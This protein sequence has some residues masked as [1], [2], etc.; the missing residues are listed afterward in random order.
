MKLRTIGGHA[1]TLAVGGLVAVV[2][3][4]LVF[5]QPLV[6]GFV[7]SGS[8]QPALEPGDGF[9]VL[10]REVVGP[11][12]RGDV[13]VFRAETIHGG[14]L[15]THRVVGVTERGFVTKGDANA[16]ADQASG[17]PPVTRTRVRGVLPQIGGH[18]LAVPHLGTVVQG[19]SD[20]LGR[21]QGWLAGLFGTDALLGTRGLAYLAFGA[22]LV[23][24]LVGLWHHR[25]TKDRRRSYDRETGRDVRLVLLSF[26]VLVVVA[27][28][29]GM[30]GPAGPEQYD[31]V[32]AHY[33][34]AGPRVIPTGG[35]EQAVHR[36]GNGGV[37]PVVVFL[38]PASGGID[39]TPREV[40]V[41]GRG[42]A[43]ATVT[44]SAPPETG[45]YRRYLVKHRYFDLLPRGLTRAL[46][47]VH[48]WLP[49]V[50]ID[51]ML[52]L[53]IYATGLALAETRR[54][55]RGSRDLP[56]RV[57]VYRWVRELY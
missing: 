51:A 48:P 31:V 10:P 53:A 12:E 17:E 23:W 14:G 39:V 8:M 34:A 44:L 20:G 33:D 7:D 16:F 26:V 41:P 3:V 29:V 54:V 52:G 42:D 38:E 25:D 13:V 56:V 45:H 37:V 27:A 22:S 19:I 30:T 9:V 55:K 4:G 24:Y 49:V 6:V 35:S 40:R 46:Y 32:S 5:G 36:M 57:R 28:T 21:F 2:V 1:G 43:N 15:V 11:V 50:V 18:V 47:G